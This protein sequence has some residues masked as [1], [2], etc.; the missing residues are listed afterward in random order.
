MLLS[1]RKKF[2][3]CVFWQEGKSLCNN[4]HILKQAK[5]P[6]FCH[7]FSIC[8][9]ISHLRSLYS[10][11]A[12]RHTVQC[13]SGGKLLP[14]CS[15]FDRLGNRINNSKL[16]SSTKYNRRLAKKYHRSYFMI[17]SKVIL[18]FQ[19]LVYC[20]VFLG[21]EKSFF[22]YHTIPSRNGQNGRCIAVFL[23]FGRNCYF[24]SE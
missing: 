23:T 1:F 7:F 12:S 18:H 15:R 20:F 2:A 6:S 3:N 10:R 8:P 5:A 21:I 17:V 24:V 4:A 11:L 22:E 14:V 16:K 13:S 9:D 19:F